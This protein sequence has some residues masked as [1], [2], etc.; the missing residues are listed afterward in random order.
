MPKSARNGVFVNVL[1]GAALLLYGYL[2]LEPIGEAAATIRAA[3][4]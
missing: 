3:L 1:L 4:V 2:A